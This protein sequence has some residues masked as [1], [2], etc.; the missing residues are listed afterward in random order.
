MLSYVF[1]GK[2]IIIAFLYMTCLNSCGF[3]RMLEPLSIPSSKPSC[4]RYMVN[5]NII[6][7]LIYLKTNKRNVGILHTLPKPPPFVGVGDLLTVGLNLL[8]MQGS[9]NEQ[10]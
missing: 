9:V 7:A 2:A 5:S 4:Y 3:Q 10:H 8:A 1:E 6:L